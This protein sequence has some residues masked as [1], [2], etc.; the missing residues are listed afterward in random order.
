MFKGSYLSVL[1]DIRLVCERYHRDYT[2]VTV[3][4]VSKTQ[5][6]EAIKEAL[7]Y[8]VTN[9]GENYIQEA[10]RKFELL[11]DNNLKWH[12]IG[13]LQKN[14]AKYAVKIFDLIHSLHSEEVAASLNKE[15][16]KINKI[17]DCLV[18]VNVARESTKSGISPEGLFDLVKFIAELKNLRLRGLM[19]IAPFVDDPQDARPFF[20]SLRQLQEKINELKLI[21]NELNLLS[22]GMSWDYR[23][24]LEEG[25]TILRI[26]RAIFGERNA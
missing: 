16:R 22:M 8:G 6:T 18:Q 2:R 13:I 9:I 26:G 17:Q 7:S 3:V 19:T 15:A 4:A 1:G 11:K 10:N 23:V 21:D 5:T 14:K 25:A 24:A 20:R 12:F